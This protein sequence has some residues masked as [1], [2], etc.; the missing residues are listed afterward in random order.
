MRIF[1][2]YYLVQLVF[3]CVQLYTSAV[4]TDELV[5]KQNRPDASEVYRAQQARSSK[6]KQNFPIA[7]D[8]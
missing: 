5:G 1:V 8:V 7:S 4:L 2:L 3:C 6:R